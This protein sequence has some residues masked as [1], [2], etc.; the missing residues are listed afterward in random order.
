MQLFTTLIARCS[1]DIDTLIE[2]LPCEESSTELQV[3]V[4]LLCLICLYSKVIGS[5]AEFKS[6][7]S[8]KSGSC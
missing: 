1:K 7:G 4:V 8:G 6:I 2:S 5:V 3:I